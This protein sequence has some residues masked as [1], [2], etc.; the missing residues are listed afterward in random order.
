VTVD[1]LIE[2]GLVVEHRPEVVQRRQQKSERCQRGENEAAR[3][4]AMAARDAEVNYRHVTPNL[5]AIDR[6]HRTPTG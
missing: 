5:I 6:H 1:A 2:K 3:Q 4:K